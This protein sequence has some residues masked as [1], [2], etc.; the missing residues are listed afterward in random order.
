MASRREF[1]RLQVAESYGFGQCVQCFPTTQHTP[2]RTAPTRERAGWRT[3]AAC[4][5][6]ADPSAFDPIAQ[7]GNEPLPL[8]VARAATQFCRDCPVR[9]QCAAEADRDQLIG[10][11]GGTYRIWRSGRARGYRTIDML[12]TRLAVTS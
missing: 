4:L 11:W 6:V 2:S 10:L 9:T 5:G 12:L 3:R 8:S 7:H 1:E